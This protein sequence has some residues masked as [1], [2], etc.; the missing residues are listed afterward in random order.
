MD[1]SKTAFHSEV[2]L[3]FPHFH[4]VAE[5]VPVVIKEAEEQGLIYP[6]TGSCIFEGTSGSTG[7]SIAGIARSRGYKAR[8]LL[9]SRL[10][11]VA[12]SCVVDIV[13]PDDVAKEK[14]QILEALGAEVEKGTPALSSPSSN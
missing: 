5:T 7:I 4:P 14:V 11:I 9:T 12:D 6:N 3:S 2:S 1:Q 8:Q 10:E 13:L